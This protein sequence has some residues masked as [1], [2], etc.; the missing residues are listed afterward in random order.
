MILLRGND[1]A[2]EWTIARCVDGSEVNEDFTGAKLSVYL[3][4]AF[5]RK[6]ITEYSVNGNVISVF[7]PGNR[8]QCG[9]LSIEAIWSKNN[10]QNW[11][12][13]KEQDFIMFTDDEK[14]AD[15]C[16]CNSDIK[17][18]TA[19]I[20]STLFGGIGHDGI[21]PHIGANGHWYIGETDT[22]V[23]A[24]MGSRINVVNELPVSGVPGEFY[25]VFE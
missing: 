1:V 16:S 15:M 2:I 25:A 13:A 19:Q 22:E 14:K 12:R 17:I 18:K 24:D 23:M 9:K 5:D 21:T 11:S 3:I 7:I 20:K 8:Q 4:N 10:G 6:E